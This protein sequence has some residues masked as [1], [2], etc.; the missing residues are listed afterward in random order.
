MH[1]NRVKIN[2]FKCNKFNILSY[3]FCFSSF[4]N[5]SAFSLYRG[6]ITSLSLGREMRPPDATMACLTPLFHFTKTY[7]K[8]LLLSSEATMLIAGD[9]AATS[10]HKPLPSG[11]CNL[12]PKEFICLGNTRGN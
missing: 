7:S 6:V 3:I 2:I 10:T 8:H 5:G 1:G 9:T 12:P 11:A 4:F